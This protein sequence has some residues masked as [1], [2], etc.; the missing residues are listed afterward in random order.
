MTTGMLLDDMD[1]DM[2]SGGAAY[3]AIKVEG[4]SKY[5]CIRSTTG[6]EDIAAL[7]KLYAGFNPDLRTGGADRSHFLV[8]AAKISSFVSSIEKRGHTFTFLD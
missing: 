8:K 5:F 4:G 6:K 2:V 7:Q 3:L 1:L